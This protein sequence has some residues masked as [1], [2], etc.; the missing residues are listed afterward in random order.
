M[1]SFWIVS[2]LTGGLLFRGRWFLLEWI[3]TFVAW[4]DFIGLGFLLNDLGVNDSDRS[5]SLIVSVVIVR[6]ELVSVS[7]F[8]SSGFWADLERNKCILGVDLSGSCCKCVFCDANF[9]CLNIECLVLRTYGV[10]SWIVSED[11]SFLTAASGFGNVVEKEVSVL[12]VV[13]GWI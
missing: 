10:F 9:S 3:G 12:I 4:V 13:E 2:V 7:T 5:E 8:C 1:V 6:S 11:D